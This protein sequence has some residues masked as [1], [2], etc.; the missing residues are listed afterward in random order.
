M[1]FLLPR[2]LGSMTPEKSMPLTPSRYC[3]LLAAAQSCFSWFICCKMLV[4]CFWNGFFHISE[5]M[6]LPEPRD[7]PIPPSSL[8]GDRC[9]W[10]YSNTHKEPA[11]VRC[12]LNT[13]SIKNFCNVDAW[14]TLDR[15]DRLTYFP[16]D[17]LNCYIF[18]VRAKDTNKNYWILR[19]EPWTILKV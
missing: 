5:V 15:L 10:D 8:I 14:T 1:C 11:K 7:T 18:K 12:L 2:C 17:L 9:S 19:D 4:S 13:F 16:L 6:W 3:A